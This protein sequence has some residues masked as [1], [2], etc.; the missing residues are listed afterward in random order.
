MGITMTVDGYSAKPNLMYALAE[1]EALGTV[2]RGTDGNIFWERSVMSGPRILEGAEA[3]EAMREAEFEKY[4]RWREIYQTAELTGT[5]TV[6]G[7]LC[8]AVTLT[9][10]GSLPETLYIS[11]ESGLVLKIV[12]TIEHQ[13]GQIPVTAYLTDYREIDGIKMPFK[14]SM[15]VMGQYRTMTMDSVAHNVELREGIFDLPEDIK[16]LMEQE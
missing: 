14:S 5:D 16:A 6:N 12:S 10:E 9:A 3:A 13:M 2:E 11:R 4:A 1:S 15:E 7:E 8:D